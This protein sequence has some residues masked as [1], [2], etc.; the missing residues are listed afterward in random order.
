MCIPCLLCL[1][2]CFTNY[3][4]LEARKRREPGYDEELELARDPEDLARQDEKEEERKRQHRRMLNTRNA[5]NTN[6]AMMRR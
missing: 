6:Q 3:F 5:A 4:S 2:K 1:P